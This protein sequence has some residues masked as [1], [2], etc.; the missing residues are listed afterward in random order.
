MD[1]I[2]TGNQRMVVLPLEAKFL[3][4]NN[5]LIMGEIT[6]EACNDWI[7]QLL[8]L[9]STLSEGETIT[10][11]INSPGG[12]VYDG[13]GVYDM[14]QNIISRG[15]NIKTVNVGT[16]WSMAMILL[17]SGTQGMRYA[18][19]HSST[20][21]H[22]I[23]HWTEGK[24][25]MLMDDLEEMRR[26]QGQMNDLITKHADPVLI[27]LCNRKDLWLDAKQAVEYKI[28]DEIKV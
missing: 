22:E 3:Q 21:V 28:V 7:Q 18:T 12:S 20:L 10:M 19:P 14:M 6:S 13:L 4:S 1:I 25:P 16:A 8:Y 17:M 11:L 15:I 5:I 24:T 9:G 27:D 23:S 2:E 26:L